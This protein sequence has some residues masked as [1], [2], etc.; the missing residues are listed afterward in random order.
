MILGDIAHIP[1][2]KTDSF[3]RV[4]H[5]QVAENHGKV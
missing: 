4:E 3:I 1:Y 5:W 2:L